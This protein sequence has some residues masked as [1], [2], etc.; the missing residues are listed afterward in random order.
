MV[1]TS[2]NDAR[3]IRDYMKE[4]IHGEINTNKLVARLEKDHVMS[5]GK[6]YPAIRLAVDLGLVK[7]RIKNRGKIEMKYLTVDGN[8]EE[9]ENSRLDKMKKLLIQFDESFDSFKKMYPGLPLDEKAYAMEGFFQFH[10]HF[11]MVVNT[12]CQKYE[13]TSKWSTL[14][15]Q[16]RSRHESLSQ[17]TS[18]G[19]KKEHAMISTHIM[20]GKLFYLYDTIKHID[21]NL[22]KIKKW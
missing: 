12:Y 6:A 18:S 20:E 17:L 2:K 9:E 8:Y 22:Q 19:T 7:K 14:L 5:H 13:K 15:H 3:Q 4:N 21:E 11:H 1:N 16:V 10:V